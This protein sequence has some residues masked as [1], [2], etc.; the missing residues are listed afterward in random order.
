MSRCWACSFYNFAQE[1]PFLMVRFGGWGASTFAFCAPQTEYFISWRLRTPGTY[2]RQ[3]P[4]VSWWL[5]GQRR[6]VFLQVL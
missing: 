5:W 2:H 1:V 6:R 4:L 3:W